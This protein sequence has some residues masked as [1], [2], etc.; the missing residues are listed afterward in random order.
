FIRQIAAALEADPLLRILLAIKEDYLAQ[1]DAFAPLLSDRLRHRFRIDLL[2]EEAAQEAIE[3]PLKLTG[4]EIDSEALTYLRDELLKVR[5]KGAG[6][7]TFEVPGQFVEP[8]QLQ[9]VCDAVWASLPEGITKIT[10][11]HVKA[12]GDVDGA[13]RRFYEAALAE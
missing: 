12:V 5:V 8:V 11:D 3:E 7:A 10:T 1:L 9:V 4:R 2:S 6:G 13:L